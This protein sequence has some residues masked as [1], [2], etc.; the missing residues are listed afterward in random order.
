MDAA[1]HMVMRA[2][3]ASIISAALGTFLARIDEDIKEWP[4]EDEADQEMFMRMLSVQFTAAAMYE[5]ITELLAAGPEG[6][7]D[8]NE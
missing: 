2:D 6:D 8:G 3:E 4:D 7:F 5:S 1:V